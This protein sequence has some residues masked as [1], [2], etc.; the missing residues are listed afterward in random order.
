[1]R[2]EIDWNI[3]SNDN[4]TPAAYSILNCDTAMVET[5]AMQEGVDWNVQDDAGNTLAMVNIGLRNKTFGLREGDLSLEETR[6][7]RLT[8]LKIMAKIT[9]I[10]WNKKNKDGLTPALAAVKMNNTEFVRVLAE[11]E[12]INWNFRAKKGKNVL[13]L[14]LENENYEILKMLFKLPNLEYKISDLRKGNIL[15]TTIQKCL[16][17]V[18]EEQKETGIN[19]SDVNN[20]LNAALKEADRV[21]AVTNKKVTKLILQAIEASK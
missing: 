6:E 7:E 11:I 12:G 2:P 18:T 13:I 17:I 15:A 1:M 9:G 20:F 3:R 19:Y 14:A 4:M 21:K 10:D 16:E 8:I 5:L